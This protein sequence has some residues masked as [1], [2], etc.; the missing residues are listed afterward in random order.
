M[1][2]YSTPRQ[3]AIAYLAAEPPQT[4]HRDVEVLFTMA[5]K[6]GTGFRIGAEDPLLWENE[7]QNEG[8]FQSQ[9]WKGK[10]QLLPNIE[11]FEEPTPTPL[12]TD[13][14]LG[15]DPAVL[16]RRNFSTPSQEA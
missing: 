2:C 1:L 9:G 3:W 12:F 13:S 7:D 8:L 6:L 10:H 5:S 15:V 16:D 14:T 4:L 11:S